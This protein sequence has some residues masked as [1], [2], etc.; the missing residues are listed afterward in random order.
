M[1]KCKQQIELIWDWCVTI[2]SDQL[3]LILKFSKLRHGDERKKNSGFF[4]FRGPTSLSNWG[5]IGQFFQQS[6]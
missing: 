4:K 6:P 3:T 1:G 5:K 2:D